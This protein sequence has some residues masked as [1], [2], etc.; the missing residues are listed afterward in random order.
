MRKR[1]AIL[2]TSLALVAL[3]ALP[4]AATAGPSASASAS[5]L[6]ITLATDAC[7]AEK[8]EIG[9]RVFRKRYGAKRAMR[10]CV[11][12][13]REEARRAVHEATAECLWEL[14][15]FGPHEFYLEWG[16]FPACVEDYAAWIMDGGSFEEDP[17]ADD[18][19]EGDGEGGDGEEP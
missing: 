9:K 5:S 12:K 16:T 3:F 7:A 17:D 13:T 8:S 4:G 18:G 15:E 11:R 6:V 19:G 10:A 1:P 2:V 14:E